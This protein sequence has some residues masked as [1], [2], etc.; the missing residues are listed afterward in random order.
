M[1]DRWLSAFKTR[2]THVACRSPARSATLLPE[3][4]SRAHRGDEA[5]EEMVVPLSDT[6]AQTR[7]VQRLGGARERTR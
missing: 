6:L 5:E 7:L 3:D 1:A 2:G 4:A